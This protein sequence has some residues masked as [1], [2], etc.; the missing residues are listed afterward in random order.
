MRAVAIVWPEDRKAEVNPLFKS[1]LRLISQV[2][3]Q[4]EVQI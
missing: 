1:S 4:K 3:D 2:A